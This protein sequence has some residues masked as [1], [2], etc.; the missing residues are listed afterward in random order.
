MKRVPCVVIAA[1]MAC[2]SAPQDVTSEAP[3]PPVELRTAI[4]KTEATTGDILLYEVVVERAAEID[5]DLGEPGA[6]IGGFR[7]VDMGRDAPAHKG[8]RVIERRWYKLRADLVG[9]Y[10]VPPVTAGFSTGAEA[11]GTS[12]QLLSS[13]IYVEVTSVLGQEGNATDIRDIK[14]LEAIPRTRWGVWLMSGAVPVVGAVAFLFWRRRRGKLELPP[15]PAHEIAYQ[16]LNSLRELDLAEG[17]TARRYCFLLSEILRA[18]VEARFGLNATDLTTPEILAR[19]DELRR[20][21]GDDKER[22]RRVLDA[23]DRVK[24]ADER[25]SVG[26][27]STAYEDALTFVEHTAEVAPA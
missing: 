17:A 12:Q 9:S 22:L 18:Y 6:A 21:A 1:Q 26:V 19:V 5:V 13:P 24:F 16:A 23:T 27:L 25:S 10:I 3:P 15:L 7:I 14:P 11:N 8:Q 2:G 20:V 4:D